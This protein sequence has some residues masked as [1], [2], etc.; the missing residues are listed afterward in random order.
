MFFNRSFKSI[1]PEEFNELRKQ[2]GTQVIDV[3]SPLEMK[4]GSIP[5]H[6]LI[7]LK[8]ESFEGQ[9]LKLDKSK[10]YLVYCKSGV[11]GKKACKRMHKL[12]FENLYNLKGGI[13]AWNRLF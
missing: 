4:E 9:I 5:G 11:R 10:M 7:N 12:G 2:K 13:N 1:E 8:S 3:R 6:R